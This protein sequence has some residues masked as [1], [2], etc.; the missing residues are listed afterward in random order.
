M[1]INTEELTN[2][3]KTITLL[4]LWVSLIL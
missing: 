4:S 2:N 1:N 3:I